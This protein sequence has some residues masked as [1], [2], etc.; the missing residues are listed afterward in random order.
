MINNT[1]D[2]QVAHPAIIKQLAVKEILFAYYQCPQ[3]EKQ[4]NLYIH[5]NVIIFTLKGSKTFHHREKSWTLNDH[6]CVFFRKAAY[7][8]E[9]DDLA[10]WE[11]L[12]FYFADEFVLKLFKE[13]RQ[14]LPLKNLPPP[15][16]DMLIKVHLNETSL[17][18]FYSM[19]PYFS[20]KIPPTES[21]LE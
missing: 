17:A 5:Y 11:V 20:Q 2:F 16:T 7:T 15:P 13:Y 6:D 14:Y 8:Q 3:I 18:F 12:A 10:G 21:L 4:L 9:R 19:V 1:Y